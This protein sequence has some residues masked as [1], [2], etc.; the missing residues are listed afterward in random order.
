MEFPFSRLG[1]WSPPDDHTRLLFVHDLVLVLVHFVHQG[2]PEWI[3]DVLVLEMGH[4]IID[5]LVPVPVS[6]QLD[7][8]H[9]FWLHLFE[10]DFLL[11]VIMRI[12]FDLNI[13]PDSP[14][15]ARGEP[16]R[17]LDNVDLAIFFIISD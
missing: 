17:C 1:S 15:Y 11:W 12:L 3:L 4:E 10:E 5:E 6:Y 13:G 7:L 16:L 2:L 8:L 9:L 14:N